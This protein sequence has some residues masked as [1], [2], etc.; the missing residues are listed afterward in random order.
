[1]W[2]DPTPCVPK[3]HCAYALYGADV[4]CALPTHIRLSNGVQLPRVGL[5]T[6]RSKGDHVTAAVSWALTSHIQHIDTASIYKV[7]VALHGTEPRQI[8][9]AQPAPAERN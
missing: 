9:N 5:G 7:C 2:A 3:M 6:F 4:M 8:D 1:M